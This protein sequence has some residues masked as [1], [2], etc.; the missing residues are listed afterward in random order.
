MKP[1]E[2][3]KKIIKRKKNEEINSKTGKKKNK[4][5]DKRNK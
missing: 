3:E 2:T 5:R 1:I 4:S